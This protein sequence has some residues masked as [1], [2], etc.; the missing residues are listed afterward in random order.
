MSLVGAC[1]GCPSG[2][3]GDIP[4]ASQQW[5]L[6]AFN[7]LSDGLSLA[8]SCTTPISIGGSDCPATLGISHC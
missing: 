2:P 6:V 3:S 1:L 4:S 7:R 5:G 8:S